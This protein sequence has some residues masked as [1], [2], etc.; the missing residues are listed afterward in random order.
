MI[1]KTDIRTIEAVKTETYCC[2]EYL[3]RCAS[4]I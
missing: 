2:N 3:A 1:L 4:Y